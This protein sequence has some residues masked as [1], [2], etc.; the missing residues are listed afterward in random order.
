METREK[1]GLKRERKGRSG[2]SSFGLEVAKL[3]CDI[4]EVRKESG[5]GWREEGLMVEWGKRK[6]EGV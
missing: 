4:P 3:S 5:R 6:E 1:R 2:R